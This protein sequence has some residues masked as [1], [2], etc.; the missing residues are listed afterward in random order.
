MCTSKEDTGVAT[1]VTSKKAMLF[2]LA[3]F[4]ESLVPT[5]RLLIWMFL[6]KPFRRIN[7]SLCL[8]EVPHQSDI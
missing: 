2:P 8:R 4:V 6:L 3:A 7:F 5:V 1:S